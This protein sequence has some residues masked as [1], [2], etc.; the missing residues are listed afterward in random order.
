MKN[1]SQGHTGDTQGSHSITVLS[2]LNH[3]LQRENDLAERLEVSVN[4]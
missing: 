2:P 1:L 4:I 3:T